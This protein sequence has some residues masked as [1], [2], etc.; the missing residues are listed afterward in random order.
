MKDS[1][2]IYLTFL[3]SHNNEQHLNPRPSRHIYT[4]VGP[5]YLTRNSHTGMSNIQGEGPRIGHH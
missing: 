5:Q 1:L 4:G 2:S 3:T